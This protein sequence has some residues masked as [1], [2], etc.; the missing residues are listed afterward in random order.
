MESCRRFKAF[1]MFQVR[2]LGKCFRPFLMES[3]QTALLSE[4]GGAMPDSTYQVRP[5]TA[6]GLS[7]RAPRYLLSHCA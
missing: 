7:T 6:F 2:H 5:V 3:K 1:V 4:E